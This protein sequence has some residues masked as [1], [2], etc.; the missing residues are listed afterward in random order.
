MLN[1]RNP[2]LTGGIFLLFA[3]IGF[4]LY[5]ASVTQGYRRGYDDGATLVRAQVLREVSSDLEACNETYVEWANVSPD[6]DDPR[7]IAAVLDH[8]LSA[9][10]CA[11]IRDLNDIALGKEARRK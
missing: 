10:Y 8:A 5:Q 6:T 3:V 7:E 4:V 2:L 11:S 9:G 1:F